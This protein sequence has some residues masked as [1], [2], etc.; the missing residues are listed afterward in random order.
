[1]NPIEL[2]AMTSHAWTWNFFASYYEL[3]HVSSLNALR[4]EGQS[5][6]ICGAMISDKWFFVYKEPKIG[7][8]FVI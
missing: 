2:P 3:S 6:G 8:E 5:L 7:C 4:F 1:M